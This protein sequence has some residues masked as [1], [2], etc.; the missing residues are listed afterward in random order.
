MA[1]GKRHGPPAS[2]T[3]HV[4]VQGPWRKSIGLLFLVRGLGLNDSP[5]ELLQC[6]S[7][8]VI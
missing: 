6:H 1:W 3:V 5:D 4:L 7:G 2:H 8:F